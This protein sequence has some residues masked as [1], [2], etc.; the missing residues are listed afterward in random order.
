MPF[1][2]EPYL[3]FKNQHIRLAHRGFDLT[4]NQC[5]ILDDDVQLHL[6][7]LSEYLAYFIEFSYIEHFDTKGI[8]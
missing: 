8:L 1:F 2:V 7:G 3:T 4:Q 6:I 5:P